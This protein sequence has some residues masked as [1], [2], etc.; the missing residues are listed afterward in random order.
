MDQFIEQHC[1]ATT[2]AVDLSDV[3]QRYASQ[4]KLFDNELF[5][6]DDYEQRN[7]ASRTDGY[8][9]YVAKGEDPPLENTYGEFPLPLFSAVVERGLQLASLESDGATLLDL[10]SGAGRL[11]LW[12]AATERWQ[13]IHGVELLPSLHA[14][15]VEKLSAASAMRFNILDHLEL[16]TPSSAIKLHLGSWDDDALLPWDT[17]DVCFAYATAFDHDANG[18]LVALSAALR[19]RLK[20][21][22]IVCTTDYRL[23]DGF[24]V[25]ET[26]A[27]VNDGV[28][29]L[30]AW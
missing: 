29:W 13:A 21:G 26:L 18:V 8:W 12:A 16:Q 4:L 10:G 15:A 25:L 1:S 24:E 22:C 28:S 23:G 5:A 7:A 2:I 27:G 17:L 6:A 14:A 9:S 19:E 20:A 30:Y 11:V 3:Q